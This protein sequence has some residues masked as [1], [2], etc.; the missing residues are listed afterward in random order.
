MTK[1]R[2]TPAAKGWRSLSGA[3]LRALPFGLLLTASAAAT[4]Q[5]TVEWRHLGGD[6][7]HTR[8]SPAANITPENFGELK[9]A[10]IW[11]GAS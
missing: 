11:D 5:D 8:Y 7:D 2:F 6:A 3:L 9:E 1:S 10:W 4:A